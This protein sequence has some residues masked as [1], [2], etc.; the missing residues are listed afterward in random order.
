M[1]NEPKVLKFIVEF[2]D[3]RSR[4]PIEKF[5]KNVCIIDSDE[6]ESEEESLDEFITNLLNK[7]IEYIKNKKWKVVDEQ[8]FYEKYMLVI[9]MELLNPE[10]NSIKL[11]IPVIKEG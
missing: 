10:N 9:L 1:E 2:I 7:T 4:K 8:N 6:V 3:A 11:S 5:E